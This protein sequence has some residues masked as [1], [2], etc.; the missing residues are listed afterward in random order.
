M[1]GFE[2]GALMAGAGFLIIQKKKMNV[3]AICCERKPI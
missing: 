3:C 1:T 2:M